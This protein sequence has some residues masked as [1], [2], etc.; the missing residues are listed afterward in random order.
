MHKDISNVCRVCMSSGSRNI[1]ENTIATSQFT[2]PNV[3]EN[4]VSSVER[5]VEKLR[6]VTMLKVSVIGVILA[7]KKK[8]KKKEKTAW[9]Y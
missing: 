2:I 4:N 7:T 1:F 6:Y 3:F 9:D 5:I 8:K